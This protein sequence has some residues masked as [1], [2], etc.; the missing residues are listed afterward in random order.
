MNLSGHHD[1]DRGSGSMNALKRHG[2]IGLISL[3]IG[4]GGETGPSHDGNLTLDAAHA[5]SDSI[6]ASGGT[7]SATSSSGVTYT[8]AVPA[9][10]LMSPVKITLTPIL[11]HD[12]LPL[13]GGFAAG[14]T[15]E[16]AG[17]RFAIPAR[18]TVSPVPAAPEGTRLAAVTFEGGGDAPALVPA[19][20]TT[21]PGILVTHFSGASFG[22]GTTAD[23]AAIS[24][25]AGQSPGAQAFKDTLAMLGSPGTL[26]D[27]LSAVSTLQHWFDAAVL[28]GIQS[29]ANDASLIVAVGDFAEWAAIANLYLTGQPTPTLDGLLPTVPAALTDDGVDAGDALAPQLRHAIDGN[30]SVC[31]SAHAVQPLYNVLYWQQVAH[32][33][34]LGIDTPEQQLDRATVIAHLCG[35]IVADSVGLPNPLPQGTDV[36]LNLAW[37]ILIDDTQPVIPADFAV[38]VSGSGATVQHASGPT[39]PDPAG[40][41]ITQ[42]FFTTVVRSSASAVTLTATACLVPPHTATVPDFCG[43]ETVTRGTGVTVAVTPGTVTVAPGGTQQFTASVSGASDQ[44]VTWSA[45]GGT[46]T[47]AGLFTAG[48]TAGSFAVRATSV[49]D[50]AAFAEAAVTIAAGAWSGDA[51]AQWDW[52]IIHAIQNLPAH[53]QLS[54]TGFTG[55]FDNGLSAELHF[56]GTV[57]TGAFRARPEPEWAGLSGFDAQLSLNSGTCQLAVTGVVLVQDNGVRVTDNN[58]IDPLTVTRVDFLSN[59]PVLPCGVPGPGQSFDS[60][61]VEFF[62]FVRP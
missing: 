2:I 53:V 13:S 56:G 39:G 42:G 18:L 38:A 49:A 61:S 11:R 3:S 62:G 47:Q 40:G 57:T 59:Q 54:T 23:L 4:C 26:M 28:P 58:L 20:G 25:A 45:A 44:S 31:R 33:L 8:L 19:I 36:S 32:I 7:L 17:L 35:R 50:P 37:G 22:F 16:P 41:P 9:G 10:A 30:N 6:G 14:A 15:F 29:A 24:T 5:A 34:N 21:A 52:A 48:S 60:F 12:G 43:T 27:P 1:P 51:T 55:S 46:I